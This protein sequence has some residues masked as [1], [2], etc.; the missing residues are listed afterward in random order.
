[1]PR[2][3]ATDQRNRNGPDQHMAKGPTHR[4]MLA[5]AKAKRQRTLG[6]D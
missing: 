6:C 5:E 2:C 4:R 1:L 3:A